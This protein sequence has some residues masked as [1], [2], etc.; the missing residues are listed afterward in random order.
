MKKRI[1]EQELRKII[2]SALLDHSNI[3]NEKTPEAPAKRSS[4]LKPG[5]QWV[6]TREDIHG[7]GRGGKRMQVKKPKPD[8][9]YRWAPNGALSELPDIWDSGYGWEWDK[10]K[11][12]WKTYRWVPP[13]AIHGKEGRL[14]KL[15]DE[16]PGLWKYFFDPDDKAH[17]LIP[18]EQW[19]N[20][21]AVDLSHG[22]NVFSGTD[23]YH[24]FSDEGAPGT[25]AASK[26]SG[27]EIDPK[28]GKSTGKL[29]RVPAEQAYEVMRAKSEGCGGA[30]GGDIS[31]PLNPFTKDCPG[32]MTKDEFLQHGEEFY[33][34]Y[35]TAPA[36]GALAALAVF[37]LSALGSYAAGTGVYTAA[38]T[39]TAGST[40][41]AGT[42][43]LFNFWG[44][45]LISRGLLKVGVSSKYATWVARGIYA[46]IEGVAITESMWCDMNIKGF[47]IYDDVLKYLD[48]I[49]FIVAGF[50]RVAEGGESGKFFGQS[51]QFGGQG[52]YLPGH[53]RT[54]IGGTFDMGDAREGSKE[55]LE[56]KESMADKVEQLLSARNE[57]DR[58]RIKKL[59]KDVESRVAEIKVMVEEGSMCPEVLDKI[60]ELK[61][62]VEVKA[63][64][65]VR[66]REEE[67][68]KTAIEKKKQENPQRPGSKAWKKAYTIRNKEKIAAMAV[69]Q[70]EIE[71]AQKMI[72]K[73]FNSPDLDDKEKKE[74][75]LYF[76]QS[77]KDKKL[78][79]S[80]K[81]KLKIMIKKAKASKAEPKSKYMKMPG[82]ALE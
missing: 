10:E 72:E 35:V 77:I 52:I 3:L 18:V 13:G 40:A 68:E 24:G 16:K 36:A 73:A 49:H 42:A 39:G 61:L 29:A 82:G 32:L 67:T 47:R 65:M 70:A 27:W 74:I 37:G 1:T 60:K 31:H 33:N 8:H 53:G 75:E 66:L 44:P 22:P 79:T 63:R 12:Q 20:R 76:Q 45:G 48:P 30:I 5:Y 46:I 26:S 50:Q 64:E 59:N 14:K 41:S 57:K 2:K 55:G 19:V 21:S 17:G 25:A 9:K 43:A 34:T 78:D 7:K 4:A 80:E 71:T 38:G 51:D 11:Q 81:K 58:L 15:M 69:L 23:W 6:T 56:A 28:T 62:D 54:G